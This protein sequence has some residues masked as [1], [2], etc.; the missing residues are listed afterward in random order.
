V[1]VC[2]YIYIYIYIRKV[3]S[4]DVRCVV[5]IK[6]VCLMARFVTS[7]VIPSGGSLYWLKVN[8]KI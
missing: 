5:L 7:S 6:E 2:I 4:G 1:C 3:G 8:V